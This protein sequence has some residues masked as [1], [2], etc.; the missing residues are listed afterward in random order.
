MNQK[1]LTTR[2]ATLCLGILACSAVMF[3]EADGRSIY[4]DKCSTCHGA[5]GLGKTAKGK[6]LKVK[7][8]KDTIAKEDA[9]AMIK[10]V[11]EGKGADMDGFKTELKADQIKAV[12]D[13]YRSLAQ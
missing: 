13:Y 7:S 12:V 9:A 8:V 5:D 1:T 4:L 11:T 6:K 3:A 10:I 2:M